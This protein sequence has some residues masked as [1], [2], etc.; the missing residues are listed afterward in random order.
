MSDGGKGRDRQ[1]ERDREAKAERGGFRKCCSVWNRRAAQGSSRDKLTPPR[2]CAP[3]ASGRYPDNRSR[4][5]VASTLS[6]LRGEDE[7][8]GDDGRS[9]GQLVAFFNARAS[10]SSGAM[11]GVDVDV[12]TPE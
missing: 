3:N 1:A 6:A 11:A 5:R 4:V 7:S 12:G 10:S 9:V 2:R 8:S